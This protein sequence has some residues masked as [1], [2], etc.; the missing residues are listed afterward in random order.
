MNTKLPSPPT[1]KLS[2]SKRLFHQNFLPLNRA[3]ELVHPK[4]ILTAPAVYAELQIMN[5]SVIL[6]IPDSTS[7]V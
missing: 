1:S 4:T 2:L 5:Y 6:Y 3:T 7:F